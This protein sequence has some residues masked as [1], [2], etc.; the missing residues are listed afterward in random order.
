MTHQASPIP[1]ALLVQIQAT[2]AQLPVKP[3]AHVTRQEAVKQ[4]EHEIRQAIAERGYSLTDIA[5]IFTA[6]G[7]PVQADTIGNALRNLQPK[8]ARKRA[9]STVTASANLA[10]K[11]TAS[12]AE[13]VAALAPAAQPVPAEQKPNLQPAPSPALLVQNVSPTPDYTAMNKEVGPD[14]QSG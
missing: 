8:A 1:I 6:A 12:A 14:G 3:K 4:L 13:S 11:P 10:P 5:Q 9:K 2:L 7:A